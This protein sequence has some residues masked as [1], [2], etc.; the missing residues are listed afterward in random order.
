MPLNI[1]GLVQAIRLAAGNRLFRLM[2]RR[3]TSECPHGYK[4]RLEHALNL[5]VEHDQHL[6]SLCRLDTYVL[7][8][9]LSAIVGLMR[10]DS[11]AVKDYVRDPAVRRGLALVLRGI[12]EYGV[13][14]P[15][16]LPAP[17]LVV[18]NLTSMCN[19]KCKHCYQRAEKPLP[20]E[21]TLQEKLK[22]IDDL[23][24]A[25]VAAVAFS[26]GE[27]LL[28][29]EFPVV[30][31]EAAS[32]GIYVSV[33]TN[34]TLISRSM[35]EK[36]KDL[37]VRYVEVSLDSANPR[38]HD[39]FRGL[40]GAW[41]KAVRGIRNCVE[42]GLTTGVATTLTSLNKHEVEEIVDLCEEL[43]V[44]RVVFFNFIPVGRGTEISMWDLT[45]EERE[46]ILKVI[47]RLATTRKIEVLSTAPQLARVAIQESCGRVVAPT[48]FAVVADPAT[49]ALAE[50]IG[51]CGAGRIYAAI[52]PNGD[53]VPC[54]FLPVKV[55]SLRE[56]SFEDIWATSRLLLCL[57]NRDDFEEPCCRCSYR[58]VCGG[59]RAR[60][61]AYLGLVTGPDPGCINIERAAPV[62]RLHQREAES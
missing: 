47:Y 22:V 36:L 34:G 19:L 11:D 6:L 41:E 61:Y 44:R 39:S 56:R 33:A 27:P 52:E 28:H 58:Y 32:R 62:E 25:Y 26:G 16:R 1:K 24:R 43:G 4:S 54:V 38:K 49:V 9:A 59:C 37:G 42:V 21:L 29:P 31:R 8:L 18:W 5:L 51:G 46:E 14:K 53:V 12:A 60:A 35:A 15:Q 40:P 17:F 2:I 55:G 57:R 48:H 30:A 7:K 45:P 3:T 23:D 13:T 10:L 50:F 20:D